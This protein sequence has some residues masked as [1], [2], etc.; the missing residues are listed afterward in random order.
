MGMPVI[1]P[2]IATRCQAITDIIE[3]VALQQTAIS[4]IL[5]A[6]GEKIQKI[7]ESSTSSEEMLAVNESVRSTI[8]AISRLEMILQSKLEL[9]QGCLCAECED[10]G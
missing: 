4:H 5:N 9:F 8:N 1:T 6:E 10:N 2:S 7:V 3:S